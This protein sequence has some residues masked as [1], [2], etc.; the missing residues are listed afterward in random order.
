MTQHS[1]T[2]KIVVIKRYADESEAF[3]DA[4]LLKDNG[5]ECSVGGGEDPLQPVL[6]GVVTLRVAEG[7]A[8]RAV[9]I[10]PDSEIEA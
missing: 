4:T 9:K 5:I 2:S 8:K 7:D 3:L 1:D 10:V 6:P